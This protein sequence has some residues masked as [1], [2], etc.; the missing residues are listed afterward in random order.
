MHP[1]NTGPFCYSHEVKQI[2]V[3]QIAFSPT[4][5]LMKLTG[6][7]LALFINISENYNDY[8]KM[9]QDHYHLGCGLNASSK[10]NFLPVYYYRYCA[11]AFYHII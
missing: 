10:Y 8:Y 5:S 4:Q 9:V 3:F 6:T 11:M 2:I 7:E 1:Q